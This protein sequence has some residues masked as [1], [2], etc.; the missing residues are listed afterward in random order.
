MEATLTAFRYA[1]YMG[2][3]SSDPSFKVDTM[4]IVDVVP[5][6]NEQDAEPELPK[7]GF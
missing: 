2:I 4:G 5:R 1:G 7:T 6:A 3:S